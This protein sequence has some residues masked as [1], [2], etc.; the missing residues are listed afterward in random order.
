MADADFDNVGVDTLRCRTCGT[1]VRGGADSKAL[2]QHLK[3]KPH[4][5]RCGP[6]PP[7]VVSVL[8][9]WRPANNAC[10]EQAAMRGGSSGGGRRDAG[11]DDDENDPAV[12]GN[13][14][15][16]E[17]AEPVDAAVAAAK[18]LV[19]LLDLEAATGCVCGPCG[20]GW[21]ARH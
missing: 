8:Q 2:K 15:E 6:G 18:Q 4:K 5:V 12:G 11:L 20:M 14:P 9:Q 16:P 1:T 3:S 10:I 7:T 13:A 17:A 19:A 21:P